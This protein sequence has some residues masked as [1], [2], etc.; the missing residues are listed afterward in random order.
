MNGSHLQTRTLTDALDLVDAVLRARRTRLVESP[1][2]R[3]LAGCFAPRP[4][5]G[6]QS[7]VCTASEYD[8]TA[9][10]IVKIEP[11]L[12][13]LLQRPLT[14]RDFGLVGHSG[15][16]LR[17]ET[18][19]NGA[20]RTPLPL[21]DGSTVTGAHVTS[22]DG[23]LYSSGL[24]SLPTL[25][26]R[27]VYLWQPAQPPEGDAARIAASILEKRGRPTVE[28]I[29]VTFP[30][31][32]TDR[33]LDHAW[34]GRLRSEDGLH[35][36]TRFV[37]SGAAILD[38]NGFFS[39]ETQVVKTKYRCVPTERHRVTI[40]GPFV[41]FLADTSGVHA[42]AWFDRDSFGERSLEPFRAVDL[43]P[44]DR[45]APPVPVAPP[46]E[47]APPGPTAPPVR[48]APPV[49]VARPAEPAGPPEA[50]PQTVRHGE[51]FEVEPRSEGDVRAELER[52]RAEY[53]KLKGS[54]SR[55]MPS[56]VRTGADGESESARP[57]SALS[58]EVWLG[59]M[60]GCRFVADAS[61]SPRVVRVGRLPADRKTGQANHLVLAHG[62]GISSTHAQLRSEG[63][64]FFV[65]DLGSTNGTFFARRTSDPAA[66]T[67][68]L[69]GE[70]F[71]VALTP[72]RVYLQVD[73]DASELGSVTSPEL[74]PV[75]APELQKI[76][77]GAREAAEHRGE[78]YIDT[79]HLGDA[80][81]RSRNEWIRQTFREAGW[82]RD[83]A[84]TE[85]WE[86]GLF[87]GRHQWLEKPLSK[88][89]EAHQD[90]EGP[91][92]SPKV[93]TFVAETIRRMASANE[94]DLGTF[95]RKDLM[96]Q[97]LNDAQ[98]AVGAWL[99][100]HLAPSIVAPEPSTDAGSRSV[101][102]TWPISDPDLPRGDTDPDTES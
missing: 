42:A 50:D 75:T 2:R 5:K 91:L 67:E 81:I 52:L 30:L 48:V 57:R 72:I 69:P 102:A 95:V 89:M 94:D 70:I 63:G 88:P 71:L 99:A 86:G 8:E 85:L 83:A 93:A 79:R 10:L 26:G 61:R 14:D 24:I 62:G 3:S 90:A 25:D 43:A 9:A 39:R 101:D 37:S 73:V 40:D 78:R 29:S 36:V 7:F 47:V 55:V 32:R 33:L 64:R 76:L 98:G 96:R 16:D 28:G 11:A 100:R 22:M 34:V 44:S 82:S 17:F 87:E 74:P 23:V 41:V 38:E 18:D 92:L 58:L 56:P 54:Q 46:V 97:L 53:E 20:E 6:L 35:S 80:L 19:P 59:P 68:V 49:G 4:A 45:V 13:G 27:L 65:R 12:L 77:A 21:A 60:E 31:A 66:E 15:L 84:L 1:D 51:R